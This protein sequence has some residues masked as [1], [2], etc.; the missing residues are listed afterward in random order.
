MAIPRQAEGPFALISAAQNFT[1][2]WADL[3]G[4][5]ATNQFNSI[6]LW[7]NL[8]INDTLNARVRLIAKHTSAGS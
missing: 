7:L 5:I 1:A 4:E 3:G 6:G 8:D 2:S